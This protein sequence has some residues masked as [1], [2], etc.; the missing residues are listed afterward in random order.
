MS[1][2]VTTPVAEL[3]AKIASALPAVILYDNT[4]PSLSVAS[5]SITVVPLVLFSAILVVALSKT[6]A[7]SLSEIVTT[8]RSSVILAPEGFDNIILMYSLDSYAESSVM[9]SDIVWAVVEFAGNVKVPLV[10]V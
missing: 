1:I 4:S 5:K 9:G 7:L 10:A 6:G 3:I 8:P 2:T